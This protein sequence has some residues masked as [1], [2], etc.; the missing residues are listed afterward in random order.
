MQKREWLFL[1]GGRGKHVLKEDGTC[2]S[3][4]V[5]V[6][7]DMVRAEWEKHSRKSIPQASQRLGGSKPLDVLDK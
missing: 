6:G 5:R 3:E 7:D 2:V 1:I 4:G